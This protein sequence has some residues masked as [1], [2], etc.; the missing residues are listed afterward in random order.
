VCTSYVALDSSGSVGT[1]HKYF[2]LALFFQ[3]LMNQANLGFVLSL[4]RFRETKKN[5]EKMNIFPVFLTKV[6]SEWL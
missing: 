4:N 3:G 5:M 1:V 2:I 6:C